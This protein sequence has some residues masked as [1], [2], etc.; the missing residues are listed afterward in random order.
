MNLKSLIAL[1]GTLCVLGLLPAQAEDNTTNIISGTSVNNAAADYF[2]GNTGTNNHLQIDSGGQLS[3]VKD[4]YVGNAATASANAALVTGASSLLGAN[5][6]V[7]VGNSGKSNSLTV[8]NGASVVATA[9]VLFGFNA[10]S[11]GNRGLVTGA[12][13]V[14]QANGVN[15]VVGRAGSGNSL[16]VSNGGNVVTTA[17][18]TSGNF[19]IGAVAGGGSNNWVLVTDSGS[20]CNPSGQLLLGA[21][22]GN[23]FNSLIISNG[24]GVTA[25]K[26][27]IIGNNASAGNNSVLVSGAGSG[28]TNYTFTSVYVGTFGQSN[29]VT[30]ENGARLETWSP[31]ALG[32]GSAA[33]NNSLVLTGTGSTWSSAGTVTLGFQGSGNSLTVADGATATLLADFA[34]GTASSE[35]RALVTGANT[36]LDVAG[37]ASIGQ[38]VSGGANS[39]LTVA[40]GALVKVTQVIIPVGASRLILNGGSLQAQADSTAFIV[41]TTNPATTGKVLVQSGGATVDSNGK[42]IRAWLPL[43]EDGAS[44]GGGLTKTGSGTLELSATNSYTG[45][46]TV[47]AGTFGGNCGLLTSSLLIKSGAAVAPGAQGIGTL[48]VA[49]GVTNEAGSTTVMEITS[50]SN[51]RDNII[52]SNNIALNGTLVVTNLGVAAFTNG[53]TFVLYQSLVG[54]SGNFTATNLPSLSGNLAWAWTPASG[55]LSV[56]YAGPATPTNIT[57]TVSGGTLGL[58][59]PE[60]HLGWYAQSNSVN[61]TDANSWFDIPGSTTVTNLSVTID[62]AAANVFY[63]LRYPQ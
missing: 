59:W 8:A 1:A 50:D 10:G 63:R 18:G 58:T 3:N 29:K 52:S 17:G 14:L 19:V 38:D 4:A 43:E 36:V 60:S 28:L 16:V 31:V 15:Q 30:I 9:Q 49:G 41:G 37:W 5:N 7:Y 56:V 24:G 53:Q 21:A 32:Y 26:D 34:I 6:R 46:T 27:I 62:P 54:I 40:N 48:A 35:N 45:P 55:T 2:A 33:S 12:G 57:Y 44:P 51:A 47:E 39:K 20:A 11:D 61:V 25:Q 22:A 42:T 23:S 13:S